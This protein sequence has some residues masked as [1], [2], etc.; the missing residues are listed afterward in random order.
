M[1]ASVVS[2]STGVIST[3]LPKLSRLIEGEYKLQKGVKRKIK[4]LKDELTSMQ[5]LLGKL[6]DKEETLDVQA[7]DW[8]NKVCELSYD[9]EDCID[10]LT[11]K[12]S[13]GIG[14][15]VNFV[16]KTASKIKNIWSRHKIDSLIEELNARA[17]KVSDCHLRYKFD[18]PATNFSQVVQIDPRLPA[19]RL[20]GIDGP[21]EEIIDWLNKD[22][23]AQQLKVVS[24]VGFGGLGKTTLA[25]QVYQKI[26]G[27][28]H[29][30]CFV[31]VSRNPNIAKI[32]ADMLKELKN[33]QSCLDPSD[34][35]RQLIDKLRAFLTHKR[36]FIIVD[37]IWSTQAWE[38]VKSALP[39]NNLNS[40]IITTTRIV[41]V[42]ESCC[43]SLA[44]HVHNIQPLRDQQSQQ[45][46]FKRVFGN[47]SSCPPHLEEISHGI[48]QKCHGL[49][50]AIITIA[51]LLTGKSNKDRW[52]QVY[53]SISSAFSYPGMR[54]ILLLSYYDLPHHL[55]TCLL[56]L[57]MFPEDYMIKREELIWRW[58][59]EGFIAEV[60]GQTVDQVAENYFNEL[61]NRSLIQPVGIMYD[62]R[63]DGCRVHDMVLELIVLLS[64]EGNF[65]S[66]VEKQ[67]YNGGGHMIRRL[68]VQS[69]HVGDEVMQE[70][71]DKWSQIRSISFYGLQEQ[72]IPHLKE[73]YSLRV[74]DFDYS[75][76]IGNQ[77]VKYIGSFF[78]LTFLRINCREVTELPEGI[79]D[80][81]YLQTLD[82]QR[83][84][85]EK[86]PPSIGR[87]QKL[88]RLFVSYSVELPDE[89][90]D[91]QALQ[92][93]PITYYNSSIKFVET[94]RRLTKLKTLGLDMPHRQ[95]LGCDTGRYEEAFK[96]SLAAMGKHGLQ[97]LNI[98]KSNILEEELMDILCCTIPCLREL[99]IEGTGITRL[100][101]QMVSLVNVT[102]LR[103]FMERIKQEDLCIL[104]G[105]PALLSFNLSVA[106]APDERLTIRSQQ[107]RCLKE[108]R[109]SSTHAPVGGLEMLFL[110]EAM[111]KLRRLYLDLEFGAQKTE[112]MMG[113]EFSIEHL[114]SLEHISIRM[115]HND[116]TRSRVEA[117]EAA[118]RNAISIQPGWS[119]LVLEVERIRFEDEDEGEDMSGHGMDEVLEEQP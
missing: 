101:K 35:V 100:S 21:R 114:A 109:F 71:M 111:P 20:V 41:S 74:L 8:R 17:Q 72:G 14:A 86:L 59:A 51:S 2:A 48:L 58:I 95:E 12:I 115:W 9:I 54:D 79:G 28:F 98:S 88:V 97:S 67:S 30:S 103:L 94:L 53:K 46:F 23:Y 118:I 55:K 64:A 105:I 7:K 73:L 37:D 77:H 34:D 32:L 26:K 84:G 44:G 83:S 4:F 43:S 31:P 80:L 63:A 39:E 82:I 110:Q 87:L 61:V 49:P 89:I 69:E 91:L 107:F 47:T 65:A 76:H 38:L 40:R 62:G 116:V 96:S 50:L 6:S 24:I 78:Q 16:K 56:Y 42:A 92:E 119:T 5:T 57:S 29:C 90:E 27:Q 13:Q 75:S 70:I 106:H 93:L 11:H 117:A 22:D 52:E 102:Y 33:Q 3:L 18:D 108:F 66:I 85:I 45:L 36:Y 25:K 1:A 68:S 10:L 15:E 112:S 19:Q 104:G 81:R 99:V 60:K 113:F